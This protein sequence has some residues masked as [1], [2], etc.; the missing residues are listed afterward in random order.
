MKLGSP[1]S[2]ALI[3][4]S[5]SL[6]GLPVPVRSPGPR[7]TAISLDFSIEKDLRYADFSD[8]PRACGKE[9]CIAAIKEAGLEPGCIGTQLTGVPFYKFP[10]S[11]CSFK[12][13]LKFF[14]AFY[15]VL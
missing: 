2:A 6:S 3:P 4:Y 12:L 11:V 10:Q 7:N 8:G 1:L 5:A 9:R 14:V 13:M 15:L